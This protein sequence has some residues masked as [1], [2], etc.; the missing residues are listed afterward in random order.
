MTPEAEPD[1]RRTRPVI[2]VLAA[3]V[4]MVLFALF[5]HQ[6]LPWMVL[7]AV[8]LLV[9]AATIGLSL[10][11]VARPAALMGLDSF[12]RKA[13]LFFLL[14]GVI[15]AA[16]GMLHRHGLGMV[17]WPANGVEI[18]AVMACLIGAAEELLYR[19][20]LLGRARALG[21]PAAVVIAAVA[22][23]AYK[24]ALF[25]LPTGST[26]IGL[27]GIMLWTAVGGIVLGLLRVCSESVIPAMFAHAAF[28]FVVY[29]ALVDAPW[30][31]WA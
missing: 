6:G 21:W 14:G 27:T 1:E 23:A 7:S 11:R 8:G 31:V 3:S 9:V 12:P 28:D 25:A 2:E 4:G 10:R 15:G 30:W 20:W 17:L 16:G 19:G 26:T 18:F 5:A 29:G 13:V 24:T 22:H